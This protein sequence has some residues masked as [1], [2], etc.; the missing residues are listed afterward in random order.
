VSANI[1]AFL[2]CDSVT[3]TDERTDVL[4]IHSNVE[5]D[6]LPGTTN[7]AFYVRL[8]GL[9]GLVDWRVY[10][11]YGSDEIAVLEIG[12]GPSTTST[13]PSISLSTGSA[14][15]RRLSQ[16]FHKNKERGG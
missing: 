15:A 8:F 1:V 2:V 12:E 3:M 11:A 9:S 10:L 5:L 14:C 4:G 6:G 13:T 16:F 7:L